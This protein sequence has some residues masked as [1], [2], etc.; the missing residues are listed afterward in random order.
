M[1]VF[2]PVY[3]PLPRVTSIASPTGESVSF[4]LCIDVPRSRPGSKE[5]A[6]PYHSLIRFLLHVS[7]ERQGFH[8]TTPACRDRGSR[9][10]DGIA[11][12]SSGSVGNGQMLYL[13]ID[14]SAVRTLQGKGAKEDATRSE[15][16][17]RRE[18]LHPREANII[19]EWSR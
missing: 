8:S 14:L 7:R 3:V 9:G 15:E 10:S 1:P 17:V 5:R 2:S 13:R 16:Q 6:R 4:C 12:K 11:S 19:T 18:N